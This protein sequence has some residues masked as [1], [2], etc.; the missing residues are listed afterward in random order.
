M[1]GRLSGRSKLK[2]ILPW[3]PGLDG[4]AVGGEDLRRSGVGEGGHVLIEDFAGRFY[5]EPFL[6]MKKKLA[7]RGG[8][9][10][11]AVVATK[12]GGRDLLA[13]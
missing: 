13:V 8:A 12:E 11:A 1:L 9:G 5:E 10:G 4:V 3:N 7:L 2:G 6:R